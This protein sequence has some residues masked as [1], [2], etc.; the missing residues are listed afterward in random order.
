MDCRTVSM[1]RDWRLRRCRSMRDILS[2]MSP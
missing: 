1:M 2:A